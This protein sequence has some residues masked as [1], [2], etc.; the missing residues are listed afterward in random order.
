MKI[1]FER[2]P[3]KTIVNHYKRH[4]VFKCTHQSH[5]HFEHRVSVYHVLK[6][7]KCY[8]EGCIYFNWR[9]RK[10]NKGTTCS[11]KFKHVGR[12]C[13]NCKEF[14]DEKEM[15]LPSTIIS[16]EEYR[17]FTRELNLFEG[18]LEDLIGKEVTYSGIINSVK[19]LFHKKSDS[20]DTHLSFKGFLINFKSGHINR[21]HFD[22]M[23]YLTISSSMQHRYN[24]C[25]GDK[26]DFYARLNETYGRI[27]LSRINR[28]TIEEKAD[29][30]PW[31]ESKAQLAKK[32]GTIIPFQY[33]KCLNCD[34][35]SLLD[36]SSDSKIHR[37]LFCLE[38]IRDPHY[39]SYSIAKILLID[40]CSR[41]QREL[42]QLQS[43]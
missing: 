21:D 30:E 7:K 38:G 11:R 20:R 4:D 37:I 25:R 27:V 19:P 12:K 32:T 8:P 23:V 13:F 3:S 39:C 31:T 42:S 41:V 40:S 34:R 16:V 1:L 14:Y 24:F 26:I 9:C 17:K 10:L 15:Y 35:G 28:I 18:W 22:D 36:I 43:H 5:T 2:P 33:E 29:L 6:A